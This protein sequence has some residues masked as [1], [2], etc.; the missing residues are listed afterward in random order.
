MRSTPPRKGVTDAATYHDTPDGFGPLESMRN[1]RPF[2]GGSG[3]GRIGRRLGMER[4]FSLQLEGPVQAMAVISKSSSVVGLQIGELFPFDWTFRGQPGTIAG[5]VWIANERGGLAAS[6]TIDCSLEGGP[7]QP[8]VSC[9]S[10]F[11]GSQFS[12]QADA[13][14]GTVAY[15]VVNYTDTTRANKL[16]AVVMAVDEYGG[17]PSGWTAAR[18]GAGAG[19]A[20]E[21]HYKIEIDDDDGN[22]LDSAVNTI[23]SWGDHIYLTCRERI[24]VL[25]RFSGALVQTHKLNGWSDEAI[26][27][28]VTQDGAAAYCGFNGSGVP[29][30]MPSGK[31]IWAFLWGRCF[32]A[33]IMKFD[34]TGDFSEPIRQVQFGTDGRLPG[35]DY[36][37]ADLRYLR[38]SEYLRRAPRGADVEAIATTPSGGVVVGMSNNGYGPNGA[39]AGHLPYGIPY[40][41]VALFSNNG[42]LLWEADT[43]SA[44]DAHT[45]LPGSITGAGIPTTFYSDIKFQQ[46]A[47]NDGGTGKDP[48]VFALRVNQQGAVFTGGR[49]TNAAS[50]QGF[51]CYALDVDRIPL[52]K[53]N[54]D[55]D[56]STGEAVRQAAVQI[57]PTTNGPWVSGVRNDQWV[58]ADLNPGSNVQAHTWLLNPL[59]GEPVRI[60]DLAAAVNAAGIDVRPDG[61][62]VVGSQY[63]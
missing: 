26:E 24:I 16:S 53:L 44:K 14:D 15:V 17:K 20:N 32:R 57:D 13:E 60:F 6:A 11:K 56:A 27:F 25:S 59:N 1:V 22:P 30:T 21:G 7:A 61:W 18:P 23:E 37:E 39:E 48:S 41:T 28:R 62:I 8:A 46:G 55:G 40:S 51:T 35:D 63:R 42:V 29:A 3:R 10:W 54:L 2:G 45:A 34:F 47:G 43:D 49:R 38:L 31:P 5:N 36:Y 33:G 9:V 19:S 4:A 12:S 52:W 58:S 50:G